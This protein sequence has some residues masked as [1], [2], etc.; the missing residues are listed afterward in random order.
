MRII[1]GFQESKKLLAREV[2]EYGCYRSL[3]GL[4]KGMMKVSPEEK[5]VSKIIREVRVRGDEALFEYTKKFDGVEISTLELDRHEIV[6]AYKMVDENLVSALRLAAKRIE[7][8]HS[9]CKKRLSASFLKAGLGRLIRPLDRVGIYIPGG[10]APYPST[11]LMAAIPARVAGVREIVI[12]TPPNSNGG[13][14]PLILVAA[15]IAGVSRVFRVGG[16]QAIAALAFGTESVAKVDKI[17]GPGNIFV[18][19]AKRMVF[20]AVAVDNLAGPSEIVILAD[21]TAD[22]TLCAADL[23][24]QAEHDVHAFTAVITTSSKLARMVSIETRRQLKQLERK[25]IASK[26]ITRCVIAV[27]DSLDEAIELVNLCAPE[28][29]SLM[30]SEASAYVDKIRNAGCIFVGSQSPVALGDY[31][32]GP[33]HVLPTG[34]SARFSSPLSVEDFL[35]TTN[36]ISLGDS[37][38]KRLAKAAMVIAEAEGMFGHA[39]AVGMRIH[40]RYRG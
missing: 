39:K 16:A 37:S 15:D 31:I 8:F 6:D 28:H 20:G 2:P 27:V 38:S 32:A 13:V 35:K 5:V 7:K 29:V 36:I 12:A 24:A 17:C 1:R 33:S 11:V 21:D 26:S 40:S 30:V 14:H 22:P 3:V 9:M 19:L 4:A 23:I 25:A 10:T 34:G 18:V